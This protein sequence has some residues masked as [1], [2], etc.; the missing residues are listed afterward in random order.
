MHQLTLL[1]TGKCWEISYV[2]FLKTFIDS[3]FAKQTILGLLLRNRDLHILL[4]RRQGNKVTKL[5]MAIIT[6]SG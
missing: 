5:T 2:E 3:L 6:S 1:L 4:R